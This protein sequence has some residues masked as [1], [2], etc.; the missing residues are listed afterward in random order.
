MNERMKEEI[1]M[2]SKK[3]AEKVVKNNEM[4]INED[5]EVDDEEDSS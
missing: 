4:M 1:E 3:D 2:Q 5:G